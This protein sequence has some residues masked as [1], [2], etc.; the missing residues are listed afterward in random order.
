MTDELINLHG[1]KKLNPTLAMANAVE[2][3]N[4]YMET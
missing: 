3:L 2:Q 1:A 4:A